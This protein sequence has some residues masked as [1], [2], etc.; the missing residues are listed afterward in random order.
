MYPLLTRA[1]T[2]PSCIICRARASGHASYHSGLGSSL[3]SGVLSTGHPSRQGSGTAVEKANGSASPLGPRGPS[4]VG[5]LLEP[6]SYV[7]KVVVDHLLLHI[8]EC[9]S[10]FV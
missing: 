2:A 9:M 5:F 1:H 3:V 6:L 4:Q 8:F 10:Q 7:T